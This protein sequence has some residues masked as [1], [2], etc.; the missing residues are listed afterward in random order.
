MP[1]TKDYNIRTATE[2]DMMDL[3]ILGKQFLKES[4]NLELLGWN[5]TK[6][7]DSLF[8]AITREDFGVFVLCNG[9]E[10][11]GMLVCFV[12]PCFFSDTKQAVEIAW[13]VDPDHRGSKKAHEMIDHYEEWARELGAVCVNM[14]NLEISKADKVAK[15]YER[16]GY[17]LAENTF[18]KEI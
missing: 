2:D 3:Y 16:R 14:M 12:T 9:V 1:R 8:D 6:V 11:V 17:T 7:Q 10:V 5:G 15:M 13:Y 18:V 4:G